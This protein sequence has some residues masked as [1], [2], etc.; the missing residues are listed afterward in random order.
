MKQINLENKC[1]YKFV[2]RENPSSYINVIRDLGI[3]YTEIEDN[4]YEM[5]LMGNRQ[6][7][8]EMQY[9]KIKRKGLKKLIHMISGYIIRK[10]AL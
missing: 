3:I 7:L 6:T 5:I 10:T 4:V 1:T 2:P 9:G 8:W